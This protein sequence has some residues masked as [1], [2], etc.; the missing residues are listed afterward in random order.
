MCPDPLTAGDVI[1]GR[2]RLEHE[3]GRG[4][5][6]V[7]YRAHDL[8]LERDVAV[9]LVAP[10]A[11]GTDGRARLL[12]EAR[13][14]ARLNHPHI[15][16]VH[17]AGEEAGAP[18]IVMEL[19][20]G[21][22]LREAGSLPRP[23]ILSL[24]AQICEA[25]SHAHARQIVHRDVKPENILLV[26]TNGSHTAKLTD[27]GV[28][29]LT[30]GTHISLQGTIVGTALYMAPEQALGESPDGRADLYSLGAVLYEL[31]T[32]RPPFSG[33]DAL[34]VIAEHL[35]APVVPPSTHRGD[36]PPALDALVLKLLAKKPED[37][38]ASAQDLAQEIRNL[39][40]SPA[41]AA[42][43]DA[44]AT[45]ALLAQLARGRLI[46]R[47]H[48]LANLRELWNGA[49]QGRGRLALISG[50]PGVGK[51]RLASE[52]VVHAQL[53]GAL[54]L[55][56]GCYEFEAATPYL[57][58]VEALRG[59]VSRKSPEQ[60]RRDLGST[61]A[62]LAR[63][64]PEIETLIGPFPASP[65]LSPNEERLRLFDN[66]ARYLKSRAAERGV[67]LFLDDLHWADPGTLALLHYLLR[68][69][70]ND[71][72][73]ILGAYRE[74]E[75]DRAHPLS[76]ALVEWNREG[77]AMRLALGRLTGVETGN[78]LATLFGQDEVS[79]DFGEAMFRETEG[80]PFFIEEVVKSLIEQGQ[81]YRQGDKW[82]RRDVS[83]LAIPQ[84][85]KEAIG[86]RLNR[87]TESCLS[88]LHAA[89]ALGKVFPFE[90]L[91][92]SVDSGED[93]VL[94][95]L[96]AASAAQLIRVD[97]DDRFAFTHDK[98]REVL[99]SE[100]NPIRRRRLHLRIGQALETL[101]ARNTDAHVQDLAFHFTQGGNLEKGYEYSMRAAA[102][103]EQVFDN[104]TA[105]RYYDNAR[106]CAESLGAPEN[107]AV[108]LERTGN[109]HIRSGRALV[110]AG[111][112]EQALTISPDPHHRAALKSLA[113]DAYCAVGDERGVARLSEA[114]AELDPVT[115]AA[116]RALAIAGMGR[117]HHYRMELGRAVELLEEAR[118]IAEPLDDPELLTM[119]Y[120][121]LAGANQHLARWKDSI[122]WAETCVA[123][124]VTR[125]YPYA[126]AIGHEFMAEAYPHL[127]LWRKALDHTTRNRTIGVAIGARD[128]VA[129]ADFGA[130]IAHYVAGDLEACRKAGDDSIRL[131]E[132]IGEIRLAT[133]CRV[134]H[135]DALTEMG[136]LAEA[137]ESIATLKE[138]VS[139]LKQSFVLL[140]AHRTVAYHNLRLGN[141]AE[142]VAD[143]ERCES[144]IGSSD[145][146][147]S[148]I[149]CYI[150]W[151]EALLGLGRV[152]EAEA[153]NR[154]SSQI[155]L[156]S[157]SPS[158]QARCRMIDGWIAQER[159]QWHEALLALN[160]AVRV[161][162]EL[163]MRLELARALASRGRV[164]QQN[165]RTTEASADLVRARELLEK[166]GAGLELERLTRELEGK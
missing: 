28:A 150:P 86:R 110:A 12:R 33:T 92:A 101:H 156:A 43:S 99:Y 70:R 68:Q 66:L 10:S 129:W 44:T 123:L 7:V 140:L 84:S 6:G 105:I 49:L 14:A 155:A 88:V 135:S 32:G 106:E 2:Y 19:V 126:E 62:E 113:G 131:A 97:R 83:E 95:A 45:V 149:R 34:V 54:V 134:F 132:E 112:F 59:W 37:R 102:L 1:A 72:V 40:S 120:A 60:L 116:S 20:E 90:E 81:I 157:E 35:Y 58:F 166:C 67:L 50:E 96:D 17:D 27:F 89:A 136:L 144:I 42:F 8:T 121:Y 119:I 108:S 47:R 11:L 48:E 31:L 152:E 163:E 18:Y 25:L 64:A 147:L 162:E 133:M 117:F 161:F 61:A 38:I 21:F 91:L 73:L 104:D 56:G 145:H 26:R 57:P 141:F 85:V 165:G 115:Q 30:Q 15:V 4:A 109:V 77:L 103:A 76:A 158:Y 78:L 51:T 65:S 74:A 153:L 46:G 71:R 22:S 80:N 29:R 118:R 24:A 69:L 137:R 138:R 142:A 16:S 146:N 52:A 23:E 75:L 100:L 151:S 87:L 139:G 128:R 39:E 143:F 63:L 79:P 5:M 122:V 13:A 3:L 159:G 160:D 98:V 114:I 94:D 53:S 93:L 124:G 82:Q 36:I 107:L 148:R 154:R 125:N 41:E 111:F 9:K 164:L 127:G 55:R 130:H